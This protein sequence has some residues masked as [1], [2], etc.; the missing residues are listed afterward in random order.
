MDN[1][2]QLFDLMEKMYSEMQ[3]GFTGVRNEI[4]DL[5]KQVTLIENDHG[6]KLEVLLDGYMQN[7]EKI[8]R[9]EHQVS[10][11]EEFIIKKVK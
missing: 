3:E 10:K 8:N 9:I 2:S 4:K 7:A 11:Q 6:E 5:K 1:K